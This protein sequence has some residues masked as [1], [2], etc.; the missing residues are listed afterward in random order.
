MNVWNRTFGKFFIGFWS[1]VEHI[2]A[3]E[4][5]VNKFQVEIWFAH[6]EYGILSC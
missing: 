1:N 3:I 5:L 2:L 4:Y 6:N